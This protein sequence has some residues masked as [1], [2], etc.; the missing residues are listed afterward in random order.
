VNGRNPHF[1]IIAATALDAVA[2]ASGSYAGA[3]NALGI[4]TS[5]LLKFL[6]SDREL[7]RAVS[8][9]AENR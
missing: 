7:W 9:G 8:E 5:Q 1:P 2:A 4:T 6:K 3:A